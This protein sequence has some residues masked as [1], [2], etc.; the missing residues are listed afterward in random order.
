MKLLSSTINTRPLLRNNLR[1]IRS[2]VP[3]IITEED[4]RWFSEHD[5]PT[6]ID[7]PTPW[8]QNHK[9]CPLQQEE[10]F[11]YYSIA[12]QGGAEI[13]K[14]PELVPVSYINI[15][16][17]DLWRVIEIAMS[18]KTNVLYFCNMGKDRTG[19]VSAIILKKLG[20]GREKIISDYVKTWENTKE[21]LEKF[22]ADNPGIDKNVIM[23]RAE[24]IETFLDMYEERFEGEYTSWK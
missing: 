12:L 4:K 11:S 9:F 16:N 7:L 6:I 5:I 23:P 21:V 17:G 18:A 22:A 2:D 20:A 19:V 10:D 14:K 24:Y 13:P 8:E 1:N 3:T 15:V